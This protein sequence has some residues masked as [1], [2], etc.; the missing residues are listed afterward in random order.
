VYSWNIFYAQTSH[1]QTQT[2]KTHH[3]PDLQE[4]TTFPLI[5]FSMLGHRAS[6]Q[7]SFCHGIPKFPK[8]GTPRTLEGHNFLCRP[9]IEMRSEAKLYPSSRA[10]QRYVACHLQANKSRQFLTFNAW[11]SNWQFDSQPFFRP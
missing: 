9:S 2:H 6:T 11:E 7:M 8:I 1:G 5:V 4:A 3:S 10:L